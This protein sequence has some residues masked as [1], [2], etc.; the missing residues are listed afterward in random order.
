MLPTLRNNNILL[1]KKKSDIDRFDIVYIK[2]G[3]DFQVRRIIGLPG[4]TI[5][6]K[7]DSLY[8]NDKQIDE[9]FIINEINTAMKSGG[10]YTQ[11]FTLKDFNL[12]QTIPPNY[13]LVLN[14][15]RNFDNDSRQYGL[16]NKKNIIGNLKMTVF[17]LEDMKSF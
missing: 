8:V 17:P 4:E 11:D 9:K 6:Y 12:N 5:Y 15:N 14:D 3:N 13:Y 2:Q 16:V 7:D 10:Q 1:L